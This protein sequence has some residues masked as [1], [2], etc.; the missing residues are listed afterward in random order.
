MQLTVAIC[1]YNPDRGTM[2]RALDAIAE[3]LGDI[4][5]AEV[6]VVD[7]NSSP[8]LVERGYLSDYP[9][10]LLRE[11]RPGLTA[12]R[13]AA[14]RTAAGEVIVF[15]DDDNI[16]AEDYLSTVVEAF[17]NDPILG[18]LGGR[19]VP[20]YNTQPPA[21]FGEFE[22]QL[23]IRRYPPELHVETTA[24]PF[25][26]YFPVGAGLAVIRDLALEYLEDCAVTSRIEGR[27]GTALSSGEDLDLGLFALSRG[28]KLAVTGALSLTH[29]I[30]DGR[31]HS[32]YLERLADGNVKSSLELERKWAPRLGHSV[33][34]VFSTSLMVLLF[35]TAATWLLGFLLPRY[36][37]RRRTYMALTRIRLGLSI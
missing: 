34:P 26:E 15:V 9:V 1:T 24:P 14:I 11:P 8:P 37:I 23:A 12:A 13:E 33:Y 4:P 22:R 31:V 20:E 35:K 6:I 16:L 21:W 28:Y 32:E 17:S 7:N 30:P 27:Q 18:S 2:I 10:R 19:I 3:Q 5:S 25:S 36:R 29:V